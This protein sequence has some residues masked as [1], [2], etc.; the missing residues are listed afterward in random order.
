[1]HV[2]HLHV[3]HLLNSA[4]RSLATTRISSGGYPPEGFMISWPRILPPSPSNLLACT[5]H[6]EMNIPCP[7]PSCLG[8]GITCRKRGSMSM[9]IH[10]LSAVKWLKTSD[11]G[12]IPT[13]YNYLF[14]IF[15][16]FF[17]PRPFET[18]LIIL[19]HEL[20][21]DARLSKK[22]RKKKKEKFPVL[23]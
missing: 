6:Y 8:S 7:V 13:F 12:Q 19:H 9:S 3:C 21:S 11:K 5:Q 14:T 15:R 16:E 10:S 20:A 1:M 22:S 4:R 18:F 23:F 17:F 2:C